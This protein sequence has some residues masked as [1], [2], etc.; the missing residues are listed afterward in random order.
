MQTLD[1]AVQLH[2]VFWLHGVS[3]PSDKC[4]EYFGQKRAQASNKVKNGFF[5]LLLAFSG[6]LC[7]GFMAF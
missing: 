2:K 1:A 3:A 7:C 5:A 6:C 4:R